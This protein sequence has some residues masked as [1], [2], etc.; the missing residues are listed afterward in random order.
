MRILLVVDDS[1]SSADVVETVVDRSWPADTI[2]RVL[3]IVAPVRAELH[4]SHDTLELAQKEMTRKA[5]SLTAR[6]TDFLRTE[7]LSVDSAVAFGDAASQIVSEAQQWQA[8]FV[9]LGAN[10]YAVEGKEPRG[11]AQSVVNHAPCKVEIVEQG[12]AALEKEIH[13]G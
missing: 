9:L 11:V 1:E 2:V 8:N 7:G 13:D 3:S 10:S 12:A 6:V 4:S 5:E